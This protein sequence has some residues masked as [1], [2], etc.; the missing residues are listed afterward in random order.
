MPKLTKDVVKMTCRFNIHT[1]PCFAEVIPND[2]NDGI[3]EWS[4]LAFF[5]HGRDQIQMDGMEVASL[6]PESIS[7]EWLDH[8][9]N[10]YDALDQR[11]AISVSPCL[12]HYP[13]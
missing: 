5:D 11:C 3:K 6:T 2:D 4:V 10:S 7:M 1:F 12:T 8:I 13:E 9:M